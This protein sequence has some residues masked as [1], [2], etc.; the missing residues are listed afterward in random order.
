MTSWGVRWRH[1][2]GSGLYLY[3][4]VL[5]RTVRLNV[6]GW[7]HYLQAQESGRP[8]L[9]SLWHGQ[10]MPFVAFGQ[11]YLNPRDFALVMVGD[12][13]GDALGSFA[14]HLGGATFRVDM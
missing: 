4:Q 2:Q 10:V 3:S 13:R 14:A 8:L 6:E 11:H 1:L 9:W 5:Y 7:D 12:D